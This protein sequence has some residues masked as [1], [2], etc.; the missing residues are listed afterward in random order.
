M[1]LQT[2]PSKLLLLTTT[3]TYELRMGSIV[4]RA[5]GI[6]HYGNAVENSGFGA[7]LSKFESQI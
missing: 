4:L 7:I 3:T 2:I 6:H 1:A 5:S